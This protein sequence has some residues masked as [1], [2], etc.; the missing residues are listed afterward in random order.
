MIKKLKGTIGII[1]ITLLMFPAN[2][3]TPFMSVNAAEENTV[4]HERFEESLGLFGQSGGAVFEHVDEMDFSESGRA[5][6]ISERSNDYDAADL[7]FNDLELKDGGTY[8]V[9]VT[10]FVGADVDVPAGSEAVLSLVDSYTWLNNT[11]MQAG[12]TFTLTS[13]FTADFSANDLLRI[14][15]N[16]SGATVPFY[17]GEV[18]ITGGATGDAEQDVEATAEVFDNLKDA[19]QDYFLIGNAVS[20]RDFQGERL[21]LLKKHHNLVT[22]E[23][24]M[25]PDGSYNN[26]REFNFDSQDRLVESALDNG[27]A[28][29]GHVLVWHQQSPEWLWQDDGGDPLSREEAL[30][31]MRAHITA[32]VEHF[33]DNVISWDVVNEAM[34]D[35]PPN[36]EDWQGSLRQSGWYQA[37][38][39][40]Y[41]EQ[42]FRMTK[43]IIDANGWDVKLYYN[44]YNDDNQ[45]K[46]EAIYQMVK[47]LNEKYGAENNGELLVDGI[48]MQGHYNLNTN[49]RNV[50]LSLEKFASLGVEVGVTELDLTGGSNN[51]QTE[52]EMQQQAFLY[53]SLFEI[54][55]ENHEHISR[56][57]FWGLDDGSSWRSEDSP[58]L[59]DRDYA[60]KTAYHAVMNPEAFLAEYDGVAIDARAGE[61]SLG[62]PE[63]DGEIDEIWDKAPVL[64][65]DRYQTAW[66]GANGQARVLWDDDNLYVLIEVND[67]ELDKSAE[68]D[69]EQDSVEVF[70]EESNQ[71]STFFQE[72]DGQYRVN[73]DNEISLNPE[74][75]NEGFESAT[76]V[77]GTNYTVEMKIP[78]KVVTPEED[79]T[80]GFDVQINDAADGARQ[81][82]A[83]WNDL[84]GVGYQDPS[85]FGNLTLAEVGEA[86]VVTDVEDVE[87]EIEDEE[88]EPEEDQ[89]QGEVEEPEES[90]NRTVLYVSLAILLV[91]LIAGGITLY[92]KKRKEK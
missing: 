67:A 39:P 33:G 4:Y 37:I 47:E 17:I 74:D 9:S 89:E 48:G 28:I 30:E 65:I 76:T 70:I 34:N 42:A 40:D 53:A 79:L 80:I 60:E 13:E 58:L 10:G 73:F 61:A 75:A 22:A 5:L 77:D 88:E 41:L 32:N 81:S 78:F 90:S 6:S 54:Y 69:H 64:P 43:E 25:K 87:E 71:G 11:A 68:A 85:V 62:T 91:V 15:T 72:G 52:D 29:H 46:A 27:F 8:E 1:L 57:T 12:E 38:G 63:I 50:R 44:D 26:S 14:Q 16:E 20:M 2:V 55:K 82:V 35:N 66:S 45:Q 7:T 23:N 19:Y 59:F 3:V 92:N 18:L 24:E 56:I 83:I 21:D 86:E 49:P 31:N 51:E 36:P 84:S